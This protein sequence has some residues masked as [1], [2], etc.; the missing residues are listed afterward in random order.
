MININSSELE[1][2]TEI[3]G[4]GRVTALNIIQYRNKNNGFDEL[5]ELKNIR[6]I[7]DRTYEKIRSKLTVFDENSNLYELKI[8]IRPQ[9]IGIE[10]PDEMHL[11]GEMNNWDPE[12]K[13]YNLIESE[14]GKWTNNFN[15]EEG[16]EYKVMYDSTSWEEDRYLGDSGENFKVSY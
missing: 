16:T 8:E 5:Q 14:D 11:V 9:E 1:E 4:I 7:A 2:L 6:G 12:D 3:S 13:T 10:N 15:L